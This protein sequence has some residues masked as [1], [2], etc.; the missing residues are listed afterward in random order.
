M[1]SRN[2]ASSGYI[3]LEIILALSIF[4]MAVT[5]LISSLGQT[6]DAMLGSNRESEIRQALECKLAEKRVLPVELGVKPIEFED[7]TVAME[8]EWKPVKMV[9]YDNLHLNNLYE[10]A[11]R[12]KWTQS[13]QEQTQEAKIL[14]Y[15]PQP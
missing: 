10:L 4:A 6:S 3:L 12:A 11:I 1:L 8:C 15:R 2:H 14:L 5:G 7:S 13:G 9:T